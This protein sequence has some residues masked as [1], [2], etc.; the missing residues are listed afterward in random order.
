MTATLIPTQAVLRDET[1]RALPNRADRWFRTVEL[2]DVRALDEV[3]GPALDIGC[4]P[5]RHVLALAERGIP[6]LGIDITER[7][8]IHARARGVPVLARCVFD[9]IPGDGR[10]R[11]ALLLDGNLGIGGDPVQLLQRVRQ[12]LAPGGEVL[13]ELDAPGQAVERQRV[14]FEIDDDAGPWFDWASVDIDGIPEVAGASDLWIRRS[15]T[16]DGRWFAWLSR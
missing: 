9:P 10:W 14:R 12:L 8:L 1:G 5:G 11:S 6:A 4:G 16:D 13:V 3:R 7:A 15:W 2:P